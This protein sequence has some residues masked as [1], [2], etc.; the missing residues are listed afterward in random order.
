MELDMEQ[1]HIVFL[2]QPQG[3]ENTN[4]TL[5]VTVPAIH[6]EGQIRI[7]VCLPSG[8]LCGVYMLFTYVVALDFGL[9]HC[10]H[11]K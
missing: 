2:P 4:P 7:I 6:L 3:T 10:T 9:S 8:Q 11:T 5:V 1:I